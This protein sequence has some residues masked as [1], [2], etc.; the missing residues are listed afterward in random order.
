MLDCKSDT[1][2]QDCGVIFNLKRFSHLSKSA[3]TLGRLGQF[4]H[5]LQKYCGSSVIYLSPNIGLTV[6]KACQ[7]LIFIGKQLNASN[8]I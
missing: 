2:P 4:A 8:H 5:L 3:I 1:I 6:N 7:L